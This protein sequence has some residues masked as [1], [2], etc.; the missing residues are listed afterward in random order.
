MYRRFS[1]IAAMT[2]AV[3]SIGFIVSVAHAANPTLIDGAAILCRLRI[4]NPDTGRCNVLLTTHNRTLNIQMVET[5]SGNIV[6]S[7]TGRVNLSNI[8]TPV[9]NASVCDSDSFTDDKAQC[10]I[11]DD[12]DSDIVGSWHATLSP[13][14]HFSLTCK[15]TETPE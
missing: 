11:V 2:V 14:G 6:A 8:D 7:C 1:S 3:A 9:P 12:S 15:G 13:S 5:P 10:T 4:M